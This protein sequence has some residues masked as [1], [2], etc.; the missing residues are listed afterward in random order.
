LVAAAAVLFA[1]MAARRA[2][3]GARPPRDPGR[4]PPGGKHCFLAGTR[5]RTPNGDVKIERLAVGDLVATFDGGAKPVKWIGRRRLERAPGEEWTADALPV[6]V[7]RSALGPLVPQA[8]LFLSP[9]HS[10]YLGGLLIPVESLINGRSIRQCYAFD[11]DVIEYFHVE[12]AS[13]DVIFAE[14]APAET[15]LASRE[16]AFDNG[17]DDAGLPAR[18]DVDQLEPYAP[19]VSCSPRAVIRSRLRSAMSPWID[20]RQPVDVIWDRLAER[21]EADLAA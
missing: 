10:V 13:H 14:G 16:S 18:L 19:S 15:L 20:R 1:A 6:K 17:A 8:D 11:A 21:A 3:A 7:A 5:I 2:H 12:L 4:N 9:M